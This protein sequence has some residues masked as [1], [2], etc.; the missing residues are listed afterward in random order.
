ME[1][2]PTS[3]AATMQ[4]ATAM[5]SMAQ[6]LK[7]LTSTMQ[8]Y[9]QNFQ[10]LGRIKDA[11]TRMEVLMEGTKSTAQRQFERIEK[12][13]AEM[14]KVSGVLMQMSNVL[15]SKADAD[16]VDTIDRNTSGFMNRVKGGIAVAGVVWIAVQ[17]GIGWALVRFID[18]TA[19]NSMAIGL[20]TQTI[21]RI[22]REVAALKILR[23]Q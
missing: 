14:E 17:A 3:I 9:D 6:E 1:D 15:A 11:V 20:H 4:Q 5:A 7:G 13:E 23:G 10:E 18:T 19:A 2:N 22:D 21:D 12:I 8:R 16:R